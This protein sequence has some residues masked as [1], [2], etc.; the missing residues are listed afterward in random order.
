MPLFFY[1]LFFFFLSWWVRVGL[2]YNL[3]EPRGER[4]LK[5]KNSLQ[6]EMRG[7]LAKK[8][9]DAERKIL[10]DMGFFMKNP[11]RMTVLAA[12]LYKKAA[13]GDLSSL[14]E[15]ASLVG[16]DSTSQSGVILLDDIGNKP[17]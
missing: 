2:G 16:A 3:D 1:V 12:A 15:I 7:L 17:A 4:A 8:A 14:R 9:S 13:G 6:D 10:C 5:R 11:T